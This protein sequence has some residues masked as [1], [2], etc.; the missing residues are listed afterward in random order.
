MENIVAVAIELENNTRRFFLT[1]GRIQ[2]IVDPVPL[3]QLI[4]RFSTNFGLG[5]KPTKAHICKSIQ[6]AS[7]EPFF[8]EVFF[9]MC[10]KP[11]PF[12]EQ[13]TSWRA[14]MNRRMQLGDEIYF[15]G[16]PDVG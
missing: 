1:W 13:Y 12:G 7:H 3:E 11:I 9:S 10:Q 16:N 2:D 4:F 14:E 6:E 5:G 15:L 8:Y